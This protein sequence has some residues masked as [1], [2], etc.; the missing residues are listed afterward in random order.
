M[1]RVKR[2]RQSPPDSEGPASKKYKTGSLDADA[3]VDHC[4]QLDEYS[5]I[6]DV[7]HTSDLSEPSNIPGHHEEWNF[8][9][10]DNSVLKGN[11]C[12][13]RNNS[14][15]TQSAKKDFINRFLSDAVSTLGMSEKCLESSSD[16][17]SSNDITEAADLIS[18]HNRNQSRKKRTSCRSS[19][20]CNNKSGSSKLSELSD[21]SG[22]FEP[23]DLKSDKCS[24]KRNEF[25][26][27]SPLSSSQLLLL[28]QILPSN[29]GLSTANQ[30]KRCSSPVNATH[31][32]TDESLQIIDHIEP[33]TATLINK[34]SKKKK[35]VKERKSQKTKEKKNKRKKK[36]NERDQEKLSKKTIKLQKST[37]ELL[38]SGIEQDSMDKHEQIVVENEKGRQLNQV[39]EERKT[40]NK[41]KTSLKSDAMCAS[42]DL[43]TCTSSKSLNKIGSL[44]KVHSKKKKVS[45]EMQLTN[46]E[47]LHLPSGRH[48]EKNFSS[49]KCQLGD[50]R[51]S[52]V[53]KKKTKDGNVPL[54]SEQNCSDSDHLNET[55]DYRCTSDDT[56]EY[57]DV[58]TLEDSTVNHENSLNEL[59]K[60]FNRVDRKM[61]KTSQTM[62]DC[63]VAC[64]ETL[65]QLVEKASSSLKNCENLSTN[66]YS[67]DLFD[68]TVEDSNSLER[69]QE[70]RAQPESALEE[71]CNNDNSSLHTHK[72][73]D[74]SVLEGHSENVPALNEQQ[75]GLNTGEGKIQRNKKK[76][77][78]SDLDNCET[79]QELVEKA[80]C[81]LRNCESSITDD[82]SPDMFE[83]N[84]E[85]T[86]NAILI[87]KKIRKNP[88]HES[89]PEESSLSHTVSSNKQ[90]KLS[91][92]KKHQAKKTS[93]L[94][95]VSPDSSPGVI[96]FCSPWHRL[97]QD[98]NGSFTAHSGEISQVSLQ[99]SHI[100][101]HVLKPHSSNDHVE[102]NKSRRSQRLNTSRVV[103]TNES[104]LD[105]TLTSAAALSL[106]LNKPSVL[107]PQN[108]ELALNSEAIKKH[109]SKEGSCLKNK[110]NIK[111]AKSRNSQNK[112]E[113]VE[114]SRSP[115]TRSK[116]TARAMQ[117]N[118]KNAEKMVKSKG[119]DVVKQWKMK[120]TR[121][122][123]WFDTEWSMA[124]HKCVSGSKRRT[125]EEPHR[126]NYAHHKCN[127]CGKA[128]IKKGALHE[129]VKLVHK[130][131][132]AH[133]CD[134]CPMS[135]GVKQTLIVHKRL[136]T[137][138]LPYE[139]RICS[140]Q[141]RTKSNLNRHYTQEH[142][143]TPSFPCSLCP[144]KNIRCFFEE[145]LKEHLGNYHSKS[146]ISTIKTL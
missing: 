28:K 113:P 74:A 50:K 30:K 44:K 2:K 101:E 25:S 88:T 31:S 1:D 61:K 117:S 92:E 22:P 57:I 38:N 5:P 20:K 26:E 111:L 52:S 27:K 107:L 64:S 11:S 145:D 79:L 41:R 37:D 128:Y 56:N 36:K 142:R 32:D 34:K 114:K 77:E 134:E 99:E 33:P 66:E 138:S 89:D 21:L 137:N 68:G 118:K 144:H 102:M 72:E 13:L 69:K 97:T 40:D 43:P 62:E 127:K 103:E 94:E 3:H 73:D 7:G 14:T 96:D 140:K 16:E 120:C 135:F 18:S 84:S 108:S 35:R 58:T 12:S 15:E 8:S 55:D 93:W 24:K 115:L 45:V 109:V 82:C 122:R 85:A 91:G 110:L 76:K 9:S 81:S 29:N 139:C 141:T 119:K 80:S 46:E 6:V 53:E 39:K 59:K 90:D 126:T 146:I 51:L 116:S 60:N 42:D 100:D 4:V 112:S 143:L 10:L 83:A 70:K 49:P 104:S 19:R 121:C 133:K 48:P 78:V 67:P 17:F 86:S 130:G 125:I 75:I 71:I 65:Q 131:L 124:L 132:R 98:S 95:N 105:E 136:H 87:K 63:K 54:D 23:S 106:H 129:H 123:S 47:I